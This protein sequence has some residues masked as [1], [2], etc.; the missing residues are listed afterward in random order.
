MYAWSNTH[1]RRLTWFGLWQR[2]KNLWNQR[3][4]I[5]EAV[6]RSREH[7]RGDSESRQF[8]LMRELPIDRDERVELAFSK[9]EQFAISLAGPSHLWGGSRV[10]SDKSPFSRRGRHSSSRTRTGQERFFRLF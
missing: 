2:L 4:Q 9:A 5:Q 10:V 1:D 3:L 7:D 8:L 6:A